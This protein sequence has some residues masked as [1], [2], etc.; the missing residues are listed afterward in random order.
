[1]S[2]GNIFI[3]ISIPFPRCSTSS[4]RASYARANPLRTPCNIGSLPVSNLATSGDPGG[5]AIGS[6]CGFSVS[7]YGLFISFA[8]SLSTITSSAYRFLW[9]P[10]RMYSYIFLRLFFFRKKRLNISFSK[11]EVFPVTSTP[12]G[13]DRRTS[14]WVA[15]SNNAALYGIGSNSN[16]SANGSP[17]PPS[18]FLGIITVSDES[19]TAFVFIF[20]TG[21]ATPGKRQLACM[22]D[23]ISLIF[24]NEPRSMSIMIAFSLLNPDAITFSG[25]TFCIRSNVS[26]SRG[27]FSCMVVRSK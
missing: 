21:P 13:R 3:A 6:K 15:F 24:R 1:M 22:Q 8:A 18:L 5:T 23:A 26:Q 10:L 4:T 2:S 9:S 11:M 17:S 16:E 20:I 19:S 12:S 14:T 25:W 7:E 27:L